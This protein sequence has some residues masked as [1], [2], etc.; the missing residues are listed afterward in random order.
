MLC[1]VRK[2]CIYQSVSEAFVADW[3]TFCGCS[4]KDLIMKCLILDPEARIT[5]QQAK[6]HTW[7]H[8]ELG[9][10]QLEQTKENI[11]NNSAKIRKF[12]RAVMVGICAA[13]IA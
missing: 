12:R 3:E 13:F 4:A 7:F 6:S 9:A 1:A 10:V 2:H 11:I 5:V 8:Q